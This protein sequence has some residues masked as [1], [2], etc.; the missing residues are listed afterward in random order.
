M[1]K[2]MITKRR[3]RELKRRDQIE[4]FSSLAL[5]TK[6]VKHCEM[7][8]YPIKKLRAKIHYITDDIKK[9]ITRKSLLWKMCIDL[10]LVN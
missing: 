3:M 1:S 10:G 8:G 7:V 6:L 2:G 5:E 4:N 9:E